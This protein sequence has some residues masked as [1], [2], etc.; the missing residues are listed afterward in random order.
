MAT[1]KQEARARMRHARAAWKA[2]CKERRAEK[3][4]TAKAA[5]KARKAEG[6][7]AARVA[8]QAERKAAVE[9]L[10]RPKRRPVGRPRKPAL[11]KARWTDYRPEFARELYRA[12][13]HDAIV[14]PS[15]QSIAEFFLVH[16]NTIDHWLDRHPAFRRAIE[17][18][19]VDRGELGA[20]IAR[21]RRVVI[22]RGEPNY[23]AKRL[24]K[25][26][27]NAR[28]ISRHADEEAIAAF[29]RTIHMRRRSRPDILYALRHAAVDA[30]EHGALSNRAIARALDIPE[31]CLGQY[32]RD[33]PKLDRAICDAVAVKK[34]ADEEWR[35]LWDVPGGW[36]A[37]LDREL[38]E[39][40]RLGIIR[41]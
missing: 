30:V 38:D 17:R 33:N 34:Q 23:N 24:D 21:N 16:P 10:S 14:R 32:R 4:A 8:A 19:L 28:L 9:R 5:E 2:L 20:A 41:G 3:R 35:A 6:R 37:K 36:T 25:M 40:R 13:R 18:G 31:A 15:R 29:Q 7:Q 27:P 1:G 12:I 39:L 22:D 26:F 11:R